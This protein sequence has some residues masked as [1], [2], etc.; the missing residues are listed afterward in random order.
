M[1]LD[2]SPEL[3]NVISNA[4]HIKTTILTLTIQNATSKVLT[5]FSIIW[6]SDLFFFLPDMTYIRTWTTL[7][8]SNILT[9]FQ[10]AQSKN[11]ASGILTIFSMNFDQNSKWIPKI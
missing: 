9:K 1:A 11:A 10:L 7:I 3:C 6:P 8:S 2:H 5:R 4:K